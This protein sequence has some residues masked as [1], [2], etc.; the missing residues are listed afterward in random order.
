MIMLYGDDGMGDKPPEMSR[1]TYWAQHLNPND[2]QKQQQSETD[3]EETRAA[4]KAKKA[5][6]KR[7][8]PAAESTPAVPEKKEKNVCDNKKNLLKQLLIF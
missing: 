3:K 4:K 2:L 5:A 7:I 1:I 6:A 8:T